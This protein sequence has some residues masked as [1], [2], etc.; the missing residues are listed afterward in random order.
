MTHES[1]V[2]HAGTLTGTTA[3]EI[4]PV[5]DQKHYDIDGVWL[6]APN[7]SPASLEL[8]GVVILATANP[9][10]ESEFG[11][12]KFVRHPGQLLEVVPTAGGQYSVT[13]SEIGRTVGP[14][15]HAG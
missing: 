11:F 15:H 10:T 3:V 14:Q 4:F 9:A 5:T 7:A 2:V 8:D 6:K 13:V 1:S 12:G